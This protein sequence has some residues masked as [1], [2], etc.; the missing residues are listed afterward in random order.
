MKVPKIFLPKKN[1]DKKIEEYLNR[2][3][4]VQKPYNEEEL[5]IGATVYVAPEMCLSDKEKKIAEEEFKKKLSIHTVVINPTK[6]YNHALGIGATDT[7]LK[8]KDL[9]LEELEKKL[10]ED[11]TILP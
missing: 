10:L 4:Y 2:V 6:E 11:Y 7:P 5:G 1:L 3:E 9:T 8:F